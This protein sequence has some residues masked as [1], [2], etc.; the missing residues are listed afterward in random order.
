MKSSNKITTM[1]PSIPKYYNKLLVI[2]GV[3][4]VFSDREVYVMGQSMFVLFV[5]GLENCS[6]RTP[7]LYVRAMN[8]GWKIKQ[9]E[10]QC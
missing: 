7:G 4:N 1:H 6:G 10:V 2:L 9:G 5:V 3:A 8:K